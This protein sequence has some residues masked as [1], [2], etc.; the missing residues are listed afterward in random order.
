MFL[1]NTDLQR[2]N[3]IACEAAVE[4]G[5]VIQSMIHSHKRLDDKSGGS[6][7]ASQVLTEADLKAQDIIFQKLQPTIKQ[8]DLGW[9]GEESED[10]H[11]RFAKDY[12]WCVDPLDGT[13]AFTEG[14]PG[15]AVSISLISK[16]GDPVLGVVYMPFNGRLISSENAVIE[17]KNDDHDNLVLYCDKSF[18]RHPRYD[19]ISQQLDEFA[20][21]NKLV[22][23]KIIAGAGAVVNAI[24]VFQHPNAC[25]FKFPKP[26]SGGGSIWDY[27]ATAAIG[28]TT[29][30][31][32][33]DSRGNKM[34][35]NRKDSAYMNHTGILY[36]SNQ[37]I[38][39]FIKGLGERL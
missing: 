36:A 26:G 16:Q 17:I 8:Y 1:S 25:Y 28:K 20:K 23:F 34:D 4:A 38:A 15:Y 18:L 2:L 6:S 11:S 30:C 32:V 29:S 31:V 5:K 12:F 9:L 3:V 24:S 13:L 10:D 37:K 22:G 39:D 33:C 19:L 14:Y 35:L 27:A 7:L 21:A